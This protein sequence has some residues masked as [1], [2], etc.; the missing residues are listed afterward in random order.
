[1]HFP[2][3]TSESV[4][5]LRPGSHDHDVPRDRRVKFDES[6]GGPR[7]LQKTITTKC[8]LGIPDKVLHAVSEDVEHVLTELHSF[9]PS[10]VEFLP[11]YDL[12]Q[13]MIVSYR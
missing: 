3:E 13:P 10:L 4:C 8:T 1:M 2:N 11:L 7:Q 5:L 12:A 9:I 6:F